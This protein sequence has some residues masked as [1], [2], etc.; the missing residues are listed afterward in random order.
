MIRWGVYTQ[1]AKWALPA[2]NPGDVIV[3]DP[4]TNLFPVHKDKIAANPNL[5]QNPGY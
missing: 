5:T 1:V 4:K 3:S 2:Y